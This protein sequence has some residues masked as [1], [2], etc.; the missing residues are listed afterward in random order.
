MMA[1]VACTGAAG[2]L[3]LL[4]WQQPFVLQGKPRA[5][6][7][8]LR[9]GSAGYAAGSDADGLSALGCGV[10]VALAAGGLQMVQQRRQSRLPRASALKEV[11]RRDALAFG[12]LMPATAW[13]EETVQ[14]APMKL[15]RV[16][17][18]VGKSEDLEKELKFWTKACQMKVLTDTTG[19]DG[20]RS[21]TVGY[22]SEKDDSSCAIE[23][24]VDPSALTRKR[25]SL[26]N[27][28][29]MQPTVNA[30]NFTQI[31][32]PDQIFDMYARVEDTG[33]VSLV[34]DARY[35]DCEGKFHNDFF[36]KQKVERFRPRRQSPRGVQVR[37]VPREGPPT[38]ELVSLNIEVPAFEPTVKF[39]KR[40]GA[41]Q[42]ATYNESEEA[43]IQ[44]FSV[45]LK[46]Q[47]GGPKLLLSPVPDN[48]IKQ[49]DRDE[50]VGLL[51]LAP[52]AKQVAD[53]AEKAMAV[54]L[55]EERKKDEADR[56]KLL[57]SGKKPEEGPKKGTL[58]RP[59]VE[60]A[61]ADARIDDGVGNILMITDSNAFKSSVA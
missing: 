50:F 53:S 4:S 35:L 38:V 12:A 11:F 10:A 16:V 14:A 59:A 51:M 56:D 36:A 31:S 41:L 13:A 2:A 26:L 20:L 34:G 23:I 21:V 9:V 8:R 46:S 55:E 57:Q 18:D 40:I 60:I 25:P 3:L 30:L 33:G 22:G 39:Y 58:A 17:V 43:P 47:V 49:R 27:Y 54:A 15:Q 45:L 37:M 29:V 28:S 44:K 61:G 19:A 48:R 7:A 24:K 1:R 5:Q 32:Q 42:E 52:N 6:S